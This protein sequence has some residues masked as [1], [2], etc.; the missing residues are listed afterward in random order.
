M[1]EL[2]SMANEPQLSGF[3]LKVKEIGNVLYSSLCWFGGRLVIKPES[4]S[5]GDKFAVHFR[6]GFSP[7]KRPPRN[8]IDYLLIVEHD[9]WANLAR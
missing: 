9:V 3:R 5:C 8:E 1:G 4:A 7:R 6:V 2:E